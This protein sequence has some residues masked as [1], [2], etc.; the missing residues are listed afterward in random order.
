M[1]K[2]AEVKFT[3]TG[4]SFILCPKCVRK[5]LRPHP[6]TQM[7]ILPNHSAIIVFIGSVV[8]KALLICLAKRL[9]IIN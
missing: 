2:K 4:L 3:E 8:G 7:S 5:L 9:A 1:A 6:T